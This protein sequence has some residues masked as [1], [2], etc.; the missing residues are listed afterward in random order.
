MSAAGEN[1]RG[2]LTLSVVPR[3]SGQRNPGMPLRLDW[4]NE[5]RVNLSAV[6][7]RVATL[8]NRRSIKNAWQVAWLLRAVTCID[9]FLR[10]A[11]QVKN[12]WIPYG[13]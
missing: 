12:I 5:V 1:Q 3:W 6:E 9:E 8:A 13:E 7:R 10:H 11:T 2:G 4:I